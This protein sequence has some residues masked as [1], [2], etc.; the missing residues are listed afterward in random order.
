M[1]RLKQ[2]LLGTAAFVSLSA[3]AGLLQ[4]IVPM[5]DE[6][7][8]RINAGVMS[9]LKFGGTKGTG[10]QSLGG[11]FGFTQ[12][13]GNDFNWGLGVVLS[14]ANYKGRL[15]KDANKDT[16]GFRTDVE[17]MMSYL[18]ELAENVRAGLLLNTGWGDQ[19]THA[20]E[21]TENRSFGDFNVKIGLAVSAAFSSVVSGYVGGQFSFHNIRVS[22][23]DVIKDKSNRYGLDVPV[24][25]V[26][27]AADRASIFVEGNSRFINLNKGFKSFTEEVSLGISYAI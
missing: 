25:L 18:P 17:L 13:V 19:L 14:Q 12:N 5:G 2:I 3:S 21:I 9:G 4:P 20:D 16:S 27:G 7:D 22:P 10:A 1:K 23:K 26:I 11:G 8:I 6:T 24:G 15:F